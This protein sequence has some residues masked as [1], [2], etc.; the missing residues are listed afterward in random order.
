MYNDIIDF[1]GWTNGTRYKTN[2]GAALLSIIASPASMSANN[3]WM[4]DE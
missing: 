2:I 4:N 1:D 3:V